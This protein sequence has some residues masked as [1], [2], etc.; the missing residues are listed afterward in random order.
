MLFELEAFWSLVRFFVKE[1]LGGVHNI[2][3]CFSCTFAYLFVL[4]LNKDCS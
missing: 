3:A 2:S 1:V 4:N